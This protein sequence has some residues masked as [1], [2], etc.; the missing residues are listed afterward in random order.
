MALAQM[1]EVQT[2]EAQEGRR[3]YKK[4]IQQFR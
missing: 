2:T 1:V 4:F 3:N